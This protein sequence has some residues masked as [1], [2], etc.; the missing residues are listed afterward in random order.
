MEGDFV[1]TMNMTKNAETFL[2]TLVDMWNKHSKV[3][4][5]L[6]VAPLKCLVI[7]VKV[8]GHKNAQCPTDVMNFFIAFETTSCKT[9]DFV[10]ANC[11]IQGNNTN[12]REQPF[13]ICTTENIESCLQV[14]VDNQNSRR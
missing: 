12:S 8:Q 9:F 11:T 2:L 4:K 7:K 3:R 6:I 10:S 5:F 14:L 1:T 13:I